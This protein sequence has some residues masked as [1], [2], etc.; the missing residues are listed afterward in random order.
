ML[1][2]KPFYAYQ[3]FTTKLEAMYPG[4]P[5]V[6]NEKVSKNANELNKIWLKMS[7]CN[8]GRPNN[9]TKMAIY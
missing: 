4:S 8:S 1:M 3:C 7:T 2:V 6:R 9:Q 5:G